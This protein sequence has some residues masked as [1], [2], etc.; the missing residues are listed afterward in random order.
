MSRASLLGIVLAFA[1]A[2]SAFADEEVEATFGDEP[3]VTQVTRVAAPVESRWFLALPL[4]VGL[5]LA[6][7]TRWRGGQKPG[8]VAVPRVRDDLRSNAA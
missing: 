8:L 5:A 3:Q 4:A 6:W 1:F 2:G 7:N